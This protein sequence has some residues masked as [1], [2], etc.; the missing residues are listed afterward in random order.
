M[1]DLVLRLGISGGAPDDP[2]A[3][4][5]PS[6]GQGKGASEPDPAG[7]KPSEANG[8]GPGAESGKSQDP[9]TKDP[10]L[11]ATENEAK[12]LRYEKRQAEEKAEKLEKQLQTIEDAKKTDLDKA[13]E[14]ASKA[15]DEVKALR[16]QVQEQEVRFAVLAEAGRL[17]VIDPESAY[18]LIPRDQVIIENGVPQNVG[19]VVQ[20]LIT[21][22]PWLVKAPSGGGSGPANPATRN[23]RT[24]TP[25]DVRKMTPE[26][27]AA[28][29]DE[30]KAAAANS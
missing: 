1:R 12:R 10:A 11:V 2:P 27:I 3:K 5:D 23:G 7:K 26:Q 9:P 19:D 18:R 13:L 16:S 8:G 4:D 24:L 29:W 22:K 21:E 14:R 6:A 17:N 30:S 20:T 25:D 15:E 28:N